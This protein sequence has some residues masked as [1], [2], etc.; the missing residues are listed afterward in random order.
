M[1]HAYGAHRYRV[2]EFQTTPSWHFSLTVVTVFKYLFGILE[3]PQWQRLILAWKNEEKWK[4]LT[5]YISSKSTGNILYG[6][7]TSF[8]DVYL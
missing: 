7:K 1:E 4:Y 2:G 3:E 6:N 8:C 5:P